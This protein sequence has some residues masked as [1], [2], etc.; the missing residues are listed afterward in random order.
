MVEEEEVKVE[1]QDGIEIELPID[2]SGPNP[3]GAEFD[4]L[5]LDMNGIVRRFHM[6]FIHTRALNS[7]TGPPLYSSGGKGKCGEVIFF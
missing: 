1:G 4:C 5:Y 3:N 7:L 2:M 6:R